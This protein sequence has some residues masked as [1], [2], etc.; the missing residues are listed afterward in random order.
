MRIISTKD[1]LPSD[2]VLLEMLNYTCNYFSLYPNHS[3]IEFNIDI[4]A[5]RNAE[6]KDGIPYSFG[7]LRTIKN[8]DLT[9]QK[10]STIRKGR[11]ANENDL[12]EYA[13]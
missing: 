11:E 4:S 12:W 9:K 2:Q 7:K 1:L 8:S 6:H 5:V 3:W 10:K 13:H